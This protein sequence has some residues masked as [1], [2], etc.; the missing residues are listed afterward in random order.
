MQR[1]E[2]APPLERYRLTARVLLEADLLDRYRVSSS[3]ADQFA[4]RRFPDGY[5]VES[6]SAVSLARALVEG[7]ESPPRFYAA[8][9]YLRNDGGLMLGVAFYESLQF[10]EELP[11][12][13]VSI[14]DKLRWPNVHRN[15]F[16]SR[17][18]E[19]ARTL[20]ISLGAT[21]CTTV[22]RDTSE[23]NAVRCFRD[24]D[25]ANTGL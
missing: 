1:V 11:A 3:S 9:I 19:N 18:N 8:P 23:I 21:R 7:T 2:V 10:G 17:D 14:A 25:P 12:P 6:S 4:R 20:R 22:N 5:R 15:D 13:S 16:F 24:E